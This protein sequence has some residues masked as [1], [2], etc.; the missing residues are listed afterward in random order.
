MP[1]VLGTSTRL[2]ASG[3]AFILETCYYRFFPVVRGS[4][5]SK[6]KSFATCLKEPRLSET[7]GWE[8]TSCAARGRSQARVLRALVF[9]LSDACAVLHYL[10]PLPSLSHSSL[11]IM[12][13]PGSSFKAQFKLLLP[14]SFIN[15][16][17]AYS[18]NIL[19]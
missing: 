19:T 7:S 18:L 1:S 5:P 11:P 14:C 6:G 9:S 8:R 17:S 16:S 12:L 13:K 4:P 10:F 15:A 3:P 2:W